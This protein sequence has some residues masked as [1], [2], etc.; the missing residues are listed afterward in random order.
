MGAAR[1]PGPGRCRAVLRAARRRARGVRGGV[2]RDVRQ[3]LGLRRPR[4][5]RGGVR[6]PGP[7][8]QPPPHRLAHGLGR[9]ARDAAAGVAGGGAAA[10]PE[11]AQPGGDGAREPLRVAVLAGA[12]GGSRGG[13][14]PG[15]GGGAVLTRCRTFRSAVELGLRR[16]KCA[17]QGAVP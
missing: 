7:G 9:G 4:H 14:G 3:R 11:A 13:G 16:S 12:G 17:M 10:R 6:R 8:P 2:L 1:G 5:R 15:P